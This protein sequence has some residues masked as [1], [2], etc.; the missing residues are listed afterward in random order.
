MQFLPRA[1]KWW[2]QEIARQQRSK[3]TCAVYHVAFVK[4]V[5]ELNG[6]VLFLLMLR[7]ALFTF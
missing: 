3:T 5:L 7:L 6:D 4:L 1:L 2:Q